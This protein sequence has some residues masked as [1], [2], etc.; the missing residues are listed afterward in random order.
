MAMEDL[1]MATQSIEAN[2]LA[3]RL[4]RMASEL[5]DLSH[6]LEI[7]KQA[8][9]HTGVEDA[10]SAPSASSHGRLKSA[11]IDI[12]ARHEE[13]LTAQQVRES[14]LRMFDGKIGR[15]SHATI[16]CRLQEQ[17]A[18]IREGHKWRHVA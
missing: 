7:V 17:G 12:V 2:Q 4:S 3:D 9:A 10:P 8:A 15:R 16:M 1:T 5:L 18:L 11:I 14:L 6:E 13:G